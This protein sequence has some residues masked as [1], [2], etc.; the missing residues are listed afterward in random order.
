MFSH[1]D[2]HF[3]EYYIDKEYALERFGNACGVCASRVRLEF[4]H[5]DST[6]KI[7]NISDKLGRV[8]REVLDKEL[9][10]CQLL[11]G[12]CHRRKTAIDN[13][14]TPGEHGTLGMYTHHKCRCDICKTAWNEHSKIYRRE[15]RKRKKILQCG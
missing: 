6:S 5:I 11:C 14:F 3:K 7:F 9:N 10:K 12:K 15:W 2:Y 13:G 1:K 4:D 8:S